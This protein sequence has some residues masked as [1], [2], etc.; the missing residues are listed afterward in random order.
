[1]SYTDLRDFA[2]E[3]SFT[4][5]VEGTDVKIEIE[6]LGGGTVGRAYDGTW[7]YIVTADGSE[8]TR[9]QDFTTGT[10]K[11]HQEAAAL[12]IDALSDE[13]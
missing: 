1:M 7:R 10:P 6:K 12:I 11:T 2:A 3:A 5:D 13:L 4:F 9:G 8:M